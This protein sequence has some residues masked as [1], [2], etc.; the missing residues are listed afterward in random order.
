MRGYEFALVT[1][2][3]LPGG[4]GG[5]RVKHGS[6]QWVARKFSHNG[7]CHHDELSCSNPKFYEGKSVKA[8]VNDKNMIYE[9]IINQQVVYEYKQMVEVY[10]SALY[11]WLF[12]FVWF[13]WTAPPIV[14]FCDKKFRKY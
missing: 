5:V 3:R 14:V 8:L 4:R 12:L 1:G 6:C 10:R 13:F 9:L 2:K 7:W 11:S